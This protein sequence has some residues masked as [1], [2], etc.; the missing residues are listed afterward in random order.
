MT[1]KRAL[2]QPHPELSLRRQC[3]LLHLSRSSLYYEAVEVS[4]EELKLMRRIDEL[5]LEHPFMGAWM[6][7]R[8][9]RQT[10]VQVGPVMLRGRYG[11]LGCNWTRLRI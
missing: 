8:Q 10:G 3:E 1:E 7:R 11:G 6:L 5:H 4:P 2:V 9:L